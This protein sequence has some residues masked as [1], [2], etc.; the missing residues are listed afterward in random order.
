MDDSLRQRLQGILGSDQVVLFM[1]GNRQGPRCGFSAKVV[2]M[3]DN[4]VPE[5]TTVDV[6]SDQGAREGMKELS[7]W[8][9]FPQLY[10]KGKFVGGC[11]IVTDL[12][13]SGELESMLG[14]E[15]AA[16]PPAPKLT[17]SAAAGA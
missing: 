14:G 1:K 15:A 12:Y 3:L 9:T 6:L 17:I 7:S 16:A 5:Y 4:F 10:V 13:E 2:E 8:P 11:D